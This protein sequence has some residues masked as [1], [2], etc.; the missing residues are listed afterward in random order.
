MDE[1]LFADMD[2]DERLHG[3]GEPCQSPGLWAHMATLIEVFS[4]IQE[5]N[6]NVANSKGL[7]LDQT[8]QDTYRLAQLLDTW[9]NALPQDVQLTESN[10]IEHSKR[11]TGGIFMGLH[12]GFHHYATLLFYQYLDTRSTTTIRSRQFAA[13][14]KHHALSYSTWLARGRQQSGCEAVYPTVGHMAIVSS[15]VLLHTLL[16]G[17]ENEL[18]Q[19]R[20]CLEANFEALLE[21]EEF[22]PIVKIMVNFLLLSRNGTFFLLLTMHSR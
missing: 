7:H 6:W 11:G 4:P 3:P 10:L 22:W 19:S 14:C 1:R 5:L 17:E 18:S 2:P 12:L 21:L 15:S 20:Q 13:R 16:F 9:E 8:E